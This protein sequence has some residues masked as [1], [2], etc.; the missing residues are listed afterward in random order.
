MGFS[1]DILF[2][3]SARSVCF[4]PRVLRV[5]CGSCV[6]LAVSIQQWD[7]ETVRAAC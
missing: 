7:S 3:F 6:S 4:H 1:M 5:A 2:L